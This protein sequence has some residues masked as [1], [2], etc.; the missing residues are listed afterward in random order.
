M[1]PAEKVRP[2]GRRAIETLEGG[3]CRRTQTG[4]RLA[5]EADIEGRGRIYACAYGDSRDLRPSP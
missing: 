5:A 1:L 4:I 2:E 3:R